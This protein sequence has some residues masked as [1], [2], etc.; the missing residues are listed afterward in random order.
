MVDVECSVLSTEH[1]ANWLT[2]LIHIEHR[3]KPVS[4]TTRL[5]SSNIQDPAYSI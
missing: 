4:R 2:G 1:L 5:A 3:V